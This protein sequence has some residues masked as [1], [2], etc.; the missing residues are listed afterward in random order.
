[1]AGC[2]LIGPPHAPLG[3][4]PLI[5]A[6]RAC[7]RQSG[8]DL[9]PLTRACFRVGAG[10]GWV[11]WPWAV[12]PSGQGPAGQGVVTWPRASPLPTQLPSFPLSTPLGCRKNLLE[13][14]ILRWAFPW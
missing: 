3:R 7:D 4:L 13:G 2:T 14:R 11:T 12:G 8:R 1:M 5:C 6:P 9:I 10:Q